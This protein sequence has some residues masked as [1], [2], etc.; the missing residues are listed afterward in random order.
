MFCRG[1]LG[2]YVSPLNSPSAVPLHPSPVTRHKFCEY[3]RPALNST[4]SSTLQVSLAHPTW[5]ALTW[6]GRRAVGLS[7]YLQISRRVH[8]LSALGIGTHIQGII[9][10]SCFADVM[11]GLAVF[12]EI[13]ER[14]C[15]LC[16]ICPMYWDLLALVFVHVGMKEPVRSGGESESERDT[17]KPGGGSLLW[18]MSFELSMTKW[19]F[20][21]PKISRS[22]AERLWDCRMLIAS[23]LGHALLKFPSFYIYL[24]K[25]FWVFWQPVRWPRCVE[26]FEN[27]PHPNSC[28]MWYLAFGLR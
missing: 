8:H 24:G 23:M 3:C 1:S 20:R 10:S 19:L 27:F 18:T 7:K 12:E 17:Q 11:F 5:V 26:L 4:S 6:K 16:C 25:A 28:E 22:S 13:N 21:S 2:P 15:T 9:A 14:Y